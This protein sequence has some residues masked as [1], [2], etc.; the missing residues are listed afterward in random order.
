M[1]RHRSS[2]P[3]MAD[4]VAMLIGPKPGK[5]INGVAIKVS[6]KA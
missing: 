4:R 5:M 2:E 3:R 6:K 1:C